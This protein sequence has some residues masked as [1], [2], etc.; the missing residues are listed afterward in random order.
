MQLGG[1]SFC[2]EFCRDR[3]NVCSSSLIPSWGQLK[4][5]DVSPLMEKKGIKARSLCHKNLTPV[6][7][8]TQPLL[9][10]DFGGRKRDPGA[11]G[12]SQAWEC[13]GRNHKSPGRRGSLRTSSG[14]EQQLCVNAPINPRSDKTGGS[15]ERQKEA[16]ADFFLLLLLLL[17]FF[18]SFNYRSA[19]G[20]AQAGVG[21]AA[22]CGKQGQGRREG[23]CRLA[24]VSRERRGEARK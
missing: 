23:S 21:N 3:V 4:P 24:R 15:S 14:W 19:D 1:S 12:W 11:A 10:T 5:P 13:A 22:G 2:W 16:N 8:K 7:G 17:S 20:S 18:K 9:K 6:A